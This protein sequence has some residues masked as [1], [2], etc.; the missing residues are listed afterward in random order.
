MADATY[1]PKVYR[2]QGGDRQVVAS[3]GSL[4]VESGGEIDIESGGSLKLAGTAISATAAEINLLDGAG[5][6]VASGT[7]AAVISDIAITYSSNDPSIT[8]DQAVTV[9][10]GSAATVA[11]LLELCEE[12]ISN[13]N[14]IIDA[15]QAYG[16]VA[17]S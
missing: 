10:D 8:P 6:A 11:E 17:T 12:L 9:A 16:I 2:Q 13:Q 15:L 1:G 5:A 14:A 4:D 7:Q 3:G